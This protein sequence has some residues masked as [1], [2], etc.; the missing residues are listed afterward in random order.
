MVVWLGVVM[1]M[2]GMDGCCYGYGVYGWG[3]LRCRGVLVGGDTVV[4]WNGGVWYRD[5]GVWM[6]V[7]TVMACMDG[8]GYGG[9]ARGSVWE[10]R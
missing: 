2:G 10:R 4:G 3:W 1:V 7:D 5:W 8:C 9:R 6:G